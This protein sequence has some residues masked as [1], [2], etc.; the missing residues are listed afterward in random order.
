MPAGKGEIGSPQ[1]NHLHCGTKFT[2]AWTLLQIF[3]SIVRFILSEN[4]RKLVRSVL[5]I[6]AKQFKI[7]VMRVSGM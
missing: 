7:N 1:N 2:S 3:N 4:P 5:L 6:S